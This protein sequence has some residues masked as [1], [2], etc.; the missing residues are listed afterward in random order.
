MMVIG[1]IMQDTVPQ[2]KIVV[3]DTTRSVSDSM[4]AH[5]PVATVTTVK[6]IA[7]SIQPETIKENTDTISSCRRN[8]ISDVTFW[9]STN[10]I[11]KIDKGQLQN[12]PYLFTGINMK[13]QEEERSVLVSHLKNGMERSTDIF[14]NDWVLPVILLSV[15]IYGIIKAESIRFFKGILKFV[16]FGGIKETASRDIVPLFQWQSTIFNLAAFIN[17]SLFAFVT[18][19]W[20]NIIPSDGKKVIYWLISLGSIIT[21]IT[22]RHFICEI[23]GNVSGEKE[24]FREYLN[25]I[26]QAYR[27]GGLL[28]LII[29]VLIL[30]THF[31]PANI[32]FYSGF[33]TVAVI[34]FVR[35]S[36][37][38]LI[39]INRHISIFYLILYLCALEILPVVILVRYV[40]GLV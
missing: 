40:T 5:K 19:V 2:K 13:K 9:D 22:I 10:V 39:F 1:F 36:R 16:S 25:S 26:Y 31:L 24:V 20:Y 23:T 11:T 6:T 4:M 3:Q 12:F 34:Y 14:N 35:F 33:S 21:A 30:Y 17:I 27:L 32:L 15:F 29:T 37:L 18:L 28:L 8:S 38:L 7:L